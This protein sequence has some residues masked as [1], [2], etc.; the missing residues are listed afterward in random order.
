MRRVVFAVA[1]A[2]ITS[3]AAC[4]TS[5]AAPIAPLPEVL[6]A[7]TNGV[8]QAHY[9]YHH[10]SGRHY[11]G[12]HYWHHHYWGRP[13]WHHHYWHHRYRGHHY[14]GRHWHHHYW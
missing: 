14:Y 9:Y 2:G 11:W 3:V 4:G 6:L 7:D 13:Y 10:Y 12:H 8:V 1:L 5:G